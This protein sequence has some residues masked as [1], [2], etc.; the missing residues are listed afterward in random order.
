VVD[1]PYMQAR[2]MTGVAI[3]TSHYMQ[4]LRVYR[5]LYEA[6]SQDPRKLKR[7]A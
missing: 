1:V 5:E 2:R 4:I 3:L 6:Q 7:G